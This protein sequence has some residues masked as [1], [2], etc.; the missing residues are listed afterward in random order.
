MKLSFSTNA[1]KNFSLLDSIRQLAGCGYS[2]IEILCDKPHL[3]PPDFTDCD[4]KELKSTADDLS[5]ALVNLN[6]FT[7]F[8]RG[9]TYNPSW[10]DPDPQVRNLRLQHTIN[11]INAAAKLNI[12]SISTEP[13]GQI[14]VHNKTNRQALLNLFE[15]GI[16]KTLKHAEQK[17]IFLLIEPEPELLIEHSSEMFDF[18]KNF[19]SRW[20]GVN[21]DI[22]HFHCVNENLCGAVDKLFP[23]IKHIH[24][25]DI[26]GRKHEHLIPGHGE[27]DFTPVLNLLRDKGYTGYVTVELYPYQ[28]F[29]K[30]AARESLAY[31]EKIKNL[32]D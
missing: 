24:L 15:Q 20:I 25:E 13:G 22:G 26:A 23:Y 1:F 11:A 5:I 17:K 18:L 31:L 32:W 2:G 6:A 8:A 21:F 9:D 29:P 16:K 12:P 30:A 7:F 4:Y 28:D 27:I 10:I 19:D 3:Y 14:S